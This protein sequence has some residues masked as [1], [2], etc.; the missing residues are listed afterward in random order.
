[1]NIPLSSRFLVLSLGLGLCLVSLTEP[2]TAEEIASPSESGVMV[3]HVD[4]GR[5]EGPGVELT[6]ERAIELAVTNHPQIREADA[7]HQQASAGNRDARSRLDWQVRVEG[8]QVHLNE[9][10]V[11]SGF[12]PALRMPA[13][14]FGKKDSRA[15]AMRNR[16]FSPGS[17]PGTKTTHPSNRATPSPPKARL[18]ISATY[19]FSPLMGMMLSG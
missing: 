15:A 14:E 1:M 8:R 10:P 2:L 13:I 11:L 7:R 4:Q 6:L 16:T 19:R 3:G 18:S 12:P 9:V 17:T 5:D